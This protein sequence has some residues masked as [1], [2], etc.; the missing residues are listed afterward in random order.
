LDIDEAQNA[1]DPDSLPTQTA[2]ELKSGDDKFWKLGTFYCNPDDPA[3]I[4]EDR[5]GFNLGFNYSRFPVKVGIAA[6][7]FS[8]AAL[9][10]WVTPL[11][12]AI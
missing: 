6:L 4:V 2:K 7:I 12:V 11:L 8:L 9:Y 1:A 3:F 10:A 5:F